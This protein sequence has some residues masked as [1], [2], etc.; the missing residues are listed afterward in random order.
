MRILSVFPLIIASLTG[1]LPVPRSGEHSGR[2]RFSPDGKWLA[3]LRARNWYVR[4]GPEPVT[5]RETVWFCWAKATEPGKQRRLKIAQWRAI[6]H[7][8]SLLDRIYFEFSAQ[9]GRVAIT[10]PGR[11]V[12]VDLQTGSRTDIRLGDEVVTSLCW[13]DGNTLGYVTYATV[14]KGPQ[15]CLRRT[16]WRHPVCEDVGVRRPIHADDNVEYPV[17]ILPDGR[18]VYEWPQE[19]WSPNGQYV[20]FRGA[21]RPGPARLLLVNSGEVRSVGREDT[22]LVA[23]AWKPDSSAVFWISSTGWG[24]PYLA[25]LLDVSEQEPVDLSADLRRFF[26]NSELSIDRLWTADGKFVVGS[27][28][29]FGGF[30]IRPHPWEVRFLGQALRSSGALGG[31]SAAAEHRKKFGGFDVPPYLRRQPA[32]G[33]LIASWGSETVVVDYE[34]RVVERLGDG[35][36]SRWTVSPDGRK[37]VCVQTDGKIKVVSLTSLR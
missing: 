22:T 35:G 11:L 9:S 4:S 7:G 8:A 37:A 3:Y 32:P 10:C 36:Y 30:L 15:G 23:A 27:T 33:I 6:R 19:Y 25:F 28:Q 1:C 12:I 31:P 21:S 13:L 2:V 29:E 18:A 5:V 17:S 34:G 20:I 16:F 14:G 26:K 24:Q